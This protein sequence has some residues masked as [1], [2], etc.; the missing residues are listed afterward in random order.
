MSTWDYK[1]TVHEAEEI[2]QHLSEA[3]EHIPP[4]IF[5]DDAGTC[6]FDEGPNPLTRAI[7]EILNEMGSRGWE[8]VHVAFKPD[9]MICFWKQSQ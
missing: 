3:V 9:Q 6:Y 4:S 7:E 5:C 1:V 2:Q 8:L